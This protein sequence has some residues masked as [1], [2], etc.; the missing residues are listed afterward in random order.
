MALLERNLLLFKPRFGGDPWLAGLALSLRFWLRC[1]VQHLQ[2]P[3][4]APDP[5]VF[6]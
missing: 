4:P 2:K 1:L 6:G 5:T 3:V